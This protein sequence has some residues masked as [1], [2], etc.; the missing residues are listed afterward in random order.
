MSVP[1]ASSPAQSESPSQ[2]PPPAEQGEE[3][4]Q[5]DQAS[6]AGAQLGVAAAGSRWEME[7]LRST[8]W[9]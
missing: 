1:H 8:F 7:A 3:A 5:Q 6:A 4:E 9:R 2:S